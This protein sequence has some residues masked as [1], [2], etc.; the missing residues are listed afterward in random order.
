MEE[1]PIT[2]F[3]V[4]CLA[5]L[6]RVRKTRKPIRITKSGKPMAEIV[7]SAREPKKKSWL[8]SMKGTVRITGDIIAPVWDEAN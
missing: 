7:P 5:I 8:G 3:K 2:K 6:E 1:I 4:D